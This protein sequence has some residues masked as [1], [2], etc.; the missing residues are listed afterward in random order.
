MWNSV[1]EV[2]ITSGRC[3]DCYTSLALFESPHCAEESKIVEAKLFDRPIAALQAL[4]RHLY[5][6][7]IQAEL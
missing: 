3:L 7:K 1:G 2:A 4:V 5:F 6:S